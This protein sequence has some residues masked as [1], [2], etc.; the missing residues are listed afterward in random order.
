MDRLLWI[1]QNLA[2]EFYFAGE[3]FSL[4]DATYDPIVHRSSGRAKRSPARIS[5]K[6]IACLK[7]IK[8]WVKILEVRPHKDSSKSSIYLQIS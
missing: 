4:V 5:N 3:H 6:F 8:R 7:R 1:E 2:A